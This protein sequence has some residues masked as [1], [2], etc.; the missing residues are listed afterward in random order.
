MF[1]NFFIAICIFTGLFFL[2]PGNIQAKIIKQQNDNITNYYNFEDRINRIEAVM[3]SAP[4]EKQKILDDA[5][6]NP[7]KYEP[8]YYTM[9]SNVYLETDKDKAVFSYMIGWLR[10]T[11]DVSMCKDVTAR[12]LILVFPLIARD[13]AEYMSKMN[14]TKY[15]EIKKEVVN[16][17]ID[18]KDRYNPQ[19]A[20]YQGLDSFSQDEVEI[21]SMRKYPS[22]QKKIR[23]IFLTNKN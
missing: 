14:D 2:I 1:K 10:S 8:I 3:K 9:L 4:E 12:S 11:Q 16:W 15:R 21:L 17:D 7:Q 20:C 18:H 13:T 6:Q 23:K 19:C 5:F 22:M